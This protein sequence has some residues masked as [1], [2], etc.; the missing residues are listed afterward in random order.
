M[1]V[2]AFDPVQCQHAGKWLSFT[3]MSFLMA[4]RLLHVHDPLLSSQLC[5]EGKQ[6]MAGF[7]EV[8]FLFFRL[9]SVKVALF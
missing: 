4:V 7:L 2:L 3:L 5:S 8:F 9:F 6:E 1:Y